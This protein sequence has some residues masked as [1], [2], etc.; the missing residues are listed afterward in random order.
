[1]KK[2]IFLNIATGYLLVL[3][4]LL[5]SCA[6]KK[7]VEVITTD[8]ATEIYAFKDSC[9]HLTLSL[10]LELP[11]GQDSVS[12]QIR[13]SLLAEFVHSACQ[14]MYGDEG[15]E[16]KPYDNDPFDVQALVAYYGRAAYDR[17]LKM[18]VSDYEERMSYLKE[19]TTM[20]DEDKAMIMNDVPMW[21]FDLTIARTTDAP[22]FV[23]YNSS[24]YCYYGGAH[25]GVVGTGNITFDKAS[26]HKIERFVRNDA[27][28]SMQPL[29]RK[30]LLQYYR[31]AGD[32][33]TDAQLS[34]RLQIEDELIPLPQQAACP[35]AAGDSL[36]FTYGQY[37][38]AAYADGMP[39]FSLAVQDV[40]PYLTLEAKA[41]MRK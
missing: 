4:M 2:T 16:I 24:A 27:A 10:S 1:M 37:E 8:A 6:G 28:A 9:K 26:G 38:I 32:T 40:L 36:C 11:T 23:V 5:T 7:E 20:T 15:M 34:E 12:M 35:N 41:L 31:E 13:D 29:I 19:D 3:A 33:I 17:L 25:G 39:S 14:P 22:T 30:G 21:E 18:A